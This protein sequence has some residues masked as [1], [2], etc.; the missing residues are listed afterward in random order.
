MVQNVHYR[1]RI[2][3]LYTL[4]GGA[5]LQTSASGKNGV[6]QKHV[7]QRAS[8]CGSTRWATKLITQPEV[9]AAR[10]IVALY[11]RQCKSMTSVEQGS[12]F[13]DRCRNQY[14]RTCS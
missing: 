14:L 10:A 12:N 1:I 11:Q 13:F 4:F 9:A 5:A 7:V 6:V 8:R 2:I 3:Q